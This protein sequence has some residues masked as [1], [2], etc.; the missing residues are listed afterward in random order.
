MQR[1]A[2]KYSGVRVSC[3]EVMV[4]VMV[5]VGLYV[6]DVLWSDDEAPS[7]PNGTGG[8]ESQVLRQR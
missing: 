6:Q 2:H 1:L 4:V 3:F 7:C 8:H 5:M